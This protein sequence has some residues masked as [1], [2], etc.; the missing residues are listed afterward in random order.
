MRG[1]ADDEL[2][3]PQRNER[4]RMGRLLM[5]RFGMGLLL[6]CGSFSQSVVSATFN[7]VHWR[8]VQPQGSIGRTAR[9]RPLVSTQKRVDRVQ[10]FRP[11]ASSRLLQGKQRFVPEPFR[12]ENRFRDTGR[13]S[14]Y[15]A[16][17]QR[18]FRPDRRFDGQPDDRT[19]YTDDALNQQFRP[20]P[21]Q[22]RRYRY[23]SRA[24][25]TAP[26]EDTLLPD[27]YVPPAAPTPGGMHGSSWMY[28]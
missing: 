1:L 6:I 14:G 4:Q 28:R 9:F 24:T 10:R 22:S 25:R 12:L 21:G 5:R 20:L 27:Y 19:T 16:G 26:V 15:S 18:Q 8:A 11:K 3:L 13:A 7:E 23:P 17:S 2:C